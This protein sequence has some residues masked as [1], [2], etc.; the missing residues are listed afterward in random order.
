[1]SYYRFGW[2]DHTSNGTLCIPS[3]TL[4][5]R[6]PWPCPW[7]LSS[8]CLVEKFYSSSL[9]CENLVVPIPLA[10]TQR[11]RFNA[12]S[13][14]PWIQH[15]VPIQPSYERHVNILSEPI[16]LIVGLP[17]LFLFFQYIPSV[18]VCV[19]IQTFGSPPSWSDEQELLLCSRYT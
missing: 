17:F 3:A 6:V 16:S 2:R 14:L 18:S 4:G 11:H 9:K 5:S 19:V 12:L 7:R 8:R 15:E 13:S 1:M 10:P